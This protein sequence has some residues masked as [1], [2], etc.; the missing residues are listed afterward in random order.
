[1]QK[2]SKMASHCWI[3][4]VSRPRQGDGMPWREGTTSCGTSP[5]RCPGH[6][7]AR[8]SHSKVP[9]AKQCGCCLIDDQTTPT[10]AKLIEVVLQHRSPELGD[11][12]N[13][14]HH[15]GPREGHNDRDPVEVASSNARGTHGRRDTSTE[16]V[17]NTATAAFVKQNRQDEQEARDDEQDFADNQQYGH[18]RI[19][20]LG[21]GIRPDLD[22]FSQNARTFAS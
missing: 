22:K 4:P 10:Y 3:L 18:A 15:N 17:R 12:P 19:P 14:D 2:S 5:T 16:H 20:S 11:Q 7:L 21:R 6:A 13:Q 9:R 1:M 8:G